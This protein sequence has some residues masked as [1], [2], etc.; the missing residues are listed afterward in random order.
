VTTGDRK[1][2]LFWEFNLRLKTDGSADGPGAG[3][4]VLAGSGM[5]GDRAAVIFSRPE[6]VSAFI[7]RECP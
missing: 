2:H 4:P 5:Q 6:E 3:K 1:T 7:R